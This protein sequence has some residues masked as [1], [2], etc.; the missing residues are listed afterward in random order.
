MRQIS[1]RVLCV[2][3]MAV[4]I[5]SL[6][7]QTIWD[8]TASAQWSG[9]GTEADPYLITNAKQL[10]GL[11]KRVNGGLN[12]SGKY[13]KLT[14][15][16]LLNDTTNWQNW[17]NQAPAN[18]WTPIGDYRTNETVFHGRLNG[19]GHTIAGLYIKNYDNG[20]TDKEKFSG[21]FG[22]GS[23]NKN[24]IIKASYVEGNGGSIGLLGGMCSADS[25]NIS[26][27]IVATGNALYVGG[28]CGRV[29]DYPNGS[30]TNSYANVEIVAK[31]INDGC[32]IGGI[33][34]NYKCTM[35]RCC[36]AGDITLTSVNNKDADICIGGLAGQLG[37]NMTAAA[38]CSAIGNINVSAKLGRIFRIGGLIGHIWW[39]GHEIGK[40][41]ATGNISVN[42]KDEV[43]AIYVGGIAGAG[44]KTV[45]SY[46]LSN[47]TVEANTTTQNC[48]VYI[49]GLVG[50][51]GTGG[52]LSCVN[53]YYAQGKLRA[54]TTTGAIYKG[55]LL[56]E[57]KED[58][59][60]NSFYNVETANIS[61][62]DNLWAKST[63]ELKT[64]L[65]YDDWAFENI[66]GRDNNINNGYPYLRW[67]QTEQLDTFDPAIAFEGTGTEKDP[68]QISTAE[69]WRGFTRTLN[70]NTF[71][72]KYITLTNDIF[73][74]DTTGWRDW[75]INI[76]TNTY[77]SAGTN[78]NSFRGHFDGAGHTIYGL[79]IN[80]TKAN[81][82]GL[83]G[84][85]RSGA[86]FKQ[87]R[88]AAS[89]VNVKSS[90]NTSYAGGLVGL[91]SN[92]NTEYNPNL[93]SI[94]FDQCAVDAYVFGQ[95]GTIYSG[96]IVGYIERA[97]IIT[98]CYVLG[99]VNSFGSYYDATG[100]VV[101]R[102]YVDYDADKSHANLVNTYAAAFIS[103]QGSNGGLVGSSYNYNIDPSITNSYF[104]K[105]V[106]YQTNENYGAQ[107]I[108]TTDMKRAATYENWD[109][110]NI[111]GRRNDTNN[112]YPYLRCFEGKDLKNSIEGIVLDKHEL[113]LPFDS[114]NASLTPTI[115]PTSNHEETTYIWSSDSIEIVSV[116]DGLLIPHRVGETM[117][118]IKTVVGDFVDSCKVS[119]C[120][121]VDSVVIDPQQVIIPVSTT[122]QLK[123]IVYPLNA[124][125]KN[126]IWKSSYNYSA[127][128]SETGLVSAKNSVATVKII[129]TTEE[130]N[131]T[132]TCEVR[133]V[134]P[135]SGV[136]LNYNTLSLV[137]GR[138][139]KLRATVTPSDATI[140]NVIW[141]NTNPEVASVD[142][143]GKVTALGGGSDTIIVTTED[144]GFADSCFL[145][146]T[147]PVTGVSLNVT[148]TILKI[149]D[150]Y[151]LQPTILPLDATNQEVT[152]SSNNTDVV[153]I[154]ED[155][156]MTAL[157]IG[158]AIVTVKTVDG[159]WTASCRVT[160]PISV[161]GFT[162][163]NHTMEI[164]VGEE[165]YILYNF[166]PTN[167]TIKK[168]NWT[169][170][171]PEVTSG[172]D[173]W[174][175][176][177]ALSVGIDTIIATT[178]DGGFT[179]TCIVT[180]ITPVTSV[181]LNVSDKT[182][183]VGD[184]FQL[185]AI[186]LPETLLIKT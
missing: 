42:V 38:E 105:E 182:L 85:V 29:N 37:I 124:T 67:S 16:I 94:R 154:T 70:G 142:A 88:L 168:I 78:N 25:C 175:Y 92:S 3:M 107:P 20:R 54:Q 53:S 14:T 99:S 160:V 59:I 31:D 56:G 76:P 106:S 172:V 146:V 28:L 44:A 17:E 73:L 103:G 125:N 13:F 30:M 82:T 93:D 7:A 26:G 61:D 111:W 145:T 65:T 34:G 47:I 81:H 5:V 18:S 183:N 9:S 1:L 122:F 116:E 69:Q 163:V 185:E 112:G 104:D 152:Y 134:R 135:V 184:T 177:N 170:T 87:L 180:V 133:I 62:N 96:G 119:V 40:S 161:T 143:T 117:V 6:Q 71:E 156:L 169:H 174:G 167:A 60:T 11:A 165:A 159:G 39:D 127:T 75:E 4:G 98:N 21:L 166:T 113:W 89:F 137:K 36:A 102:A 68:Y 115:L 144:G 139:S 150:S 132:D 118:R 109:F 149:G 148:D 48:D 63:Q 178:V 8:G 162:L 101:G 49:G 74:N 79:Y 51:G 186:I 32:Y 123:A 33:T 121:P 10:A 155:G 138:T 153:S 141:S 164:A 136:T 57:I 95:N 83:F 131:F 15:D 173:Q 110:T 108:L 55:G 12:Y 140:K 158:D 23:Q 77:Q 90:E 147:V 114:L 64:K 72:G 171:N 120:V 130:N 128:V 179:D 126:V 97:T 46:S 151:Q 22:A 84:V 19:D 35:K 80:E 58:N 45:D 181:T 157:T 52:Q 129:V 24:V 41:F 100:G 176:I 2:L 50:H 43:Q 91:I 66:W 27:K 86:T